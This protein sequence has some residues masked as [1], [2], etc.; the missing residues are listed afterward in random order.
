MEIA[1]STPL[2]WIK[3][4][5]R[6]PAEDTISGSKCF[7]S[8]TRVDAVQAVIP[9]RNVVVFR[10]AVALAGLDGYPCEDR[11]ALS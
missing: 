10:I 6:D 9:R 1:E 2:V 5:R 4:L 11:A 3:T 7:M 8:S